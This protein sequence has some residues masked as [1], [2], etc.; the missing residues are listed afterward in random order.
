MKFYHPGPSVVIRKPLTLSRIT[1]LSK[2][3]PFAS[4]AAIHV[5]PRVLISF[6]R[7]G[8]NTGN[9]TEGL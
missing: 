6:V 9:F 4:S 5:G 1:P 3:S 2:A 7:R 8:N